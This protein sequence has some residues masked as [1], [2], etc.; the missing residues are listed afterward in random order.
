MKPIRVGDRWLELG[1]DEQ[2]V[3]EPG[4]PC[5]AEREPCGCVFLFTGVVHRCTVHEQ[6]AASP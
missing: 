3:Y 2:S 5:V 4:G 6:D 1:A